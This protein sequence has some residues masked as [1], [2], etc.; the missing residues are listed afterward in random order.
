MMGPD[1]NKQTARRFQE[2]HDEGDL[3]AV[4]ATLAPGLVVAA[5]RGDAMT[6]CRMARSSST[7]RGSMSWR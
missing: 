1:A 5:N 6:A 2:S 3:A 4:A 7:A